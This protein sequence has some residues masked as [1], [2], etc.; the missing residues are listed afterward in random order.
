MSL[1][2]PY[3]LVDGAASIRLSRL[4]RPR[5]VSIRSLTSRGNYGHAS[6]ADPREQAGS[7]TIPSQPPADFGSLSELAVGA[8]VCS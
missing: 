8:C 2:G 4:G 5:G 1:F 7:R 3:S 6:K